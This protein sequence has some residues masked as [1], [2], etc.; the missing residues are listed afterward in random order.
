MSTPKKYH[1]FKMKSD[2]FENISIKL[3][4][5]QKKGDT[6]ILVFLKVILYS[7]KTDGYLYY[8]KMMPT[9]QEELALGVGV[10]TSI[11]KELM[12]YLQEFDVIEKI[13]ENTYYIK[14]IDD[15]VGFESDSA[16]RMRKKRASHCAHNVE[17]CAPEIEKEIEIELELE[18]SR[19]D[20]SVS[21]FPKNG[22]SQNVTAEQKNKNK[23]NFD[24]DKKY[25]FMNHNGPRNKEMEKFLEK[26]QNEKL[27]YVPKGENKEGSP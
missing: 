11:I 2:F 6:L 19:E 5:N 14:I 22:K 15:C 8:K 25:S 13:D 27:V 17:Q 10:K 18:K 20:A 21:T 16:A 24:K 1:W 7:L 3:L 9:F 12:T 23:N 26:M 4:K